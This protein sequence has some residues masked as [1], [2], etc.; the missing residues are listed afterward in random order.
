MQREQALPRPERM[1]RW[2]GWGARC[3]ISLGLSAVRLPG[4]SAPF[5]LGC[6]AASGIGGNSTAAFLGAALG[7]FLFLPFEE[8]LPQLAAVVLILTA[9]AALRDTRWFRSRIAQAV[10]AGGLSLAV[11]MIYVLQAAAP[12][13]RLPGCV[14]AAILTGVSCWMYAPLL[15]RRE[16]EQQWMSLRFLAVTMLSALAGVGIGAFSVGR[17]LLVCLLLVTGWQRGIS[18]AM[19]TG[20]WAGLLMDLCLDL[21]TLFFAAAYGLVGMAA[22]ARGGKSRLTV[23]VAGLGVTM[24]LVMGLTDDL[25]GSML[26]E[27]MAASLLLLAIPSRL[28]GGKRLQ[29]DTDAASVVTE[30]LRRQL[31]RTASAFRDL[32]DSL[33]RT[34]AQTTEENPAVIYDRAAERVCRECSLCELCWKKEYISTFNALNDATPFLLERG[35]P[36]AK[37]FPAYFSSRCIHMPEFLAAVGSEL[38]SFLLRRQ[39]RRQLEETRHTQRVQYARMGELFSAAAA[40]LGESTAAVAVTERA[41]Q[42]GAVLRPREGESVCGDSVTSF[43]SH[44]GQLCLLL[45]DGS[46]CGEAARR[47]SALTSRLLRQFL[48]AGIDTEAAL[49]TLNAAMAL[50]SEESGA[51]STID[52][53]TVALGSGDTAIY[54]YGAAPTYVKKGGSVRRITGNAFPVGLRESAAEPDITRLTLKEG[55]FVVMVSDGIADP[56]EDDWLQNL[57]AGWD[58]DDPQV[59]AGLI[60]QETVRRGEPTD[61]CGVQVLYFPMSDRRAV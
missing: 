11:G 58:G 41:Y 26:G 13:R 55:S 3:L 45:S 27:T 31:N 48:E 23:A 38:S 4:G 5:A 44:D 19:V 37:D 47:E 56:S 1:S 53:M 54:K 60:L 12:L 36:L 51:F 46:G 29:K 30:K 57:L 28:F 21:G 16:P 14:T 6:T 10:C 24:A 8:G 52:L 42:I 59:L 39:Y 7:A 25:A 18:A 40:G 15:G 17:A 20:L 2:L 22:G 32:Y 50:R 9:T 61:D 35:R 34:A 43:E 49:K 33:S